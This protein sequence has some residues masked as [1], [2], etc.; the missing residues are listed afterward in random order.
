[1]PRPRLQ[2]NI[3]CLT[4]IECLNLMKIQN[5]SKFQ[6]IKS[7]CLEIRIEIIKIKL[8]KHLEKL[9]LRQTCKF[10]CSS[11]SILETPSHALLDSQMFM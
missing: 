11:G 7:S 1:M 2:R 8:Q 9:Y 6:T 3:S 4:A 10:S 5:E